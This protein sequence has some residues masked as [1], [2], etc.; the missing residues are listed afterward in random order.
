MRPKQPVTDSKMSDVLAQ[1]GKLADAESFQFPNTNVVISAANRIDESNSLRPTEESKPFI[2][3]KEYAASLLGGGRFSIWLSTAD[4]SRAVPKAA[5]GARRWGTVLIDGHPAWHAN[6]F[7]LWS[8]RGNE[9]EVTLTP[10]KGRRPSDA[11][12]LAIGECLRK[13]LAVHHPDLRALR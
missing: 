2:N 9:K 4:S 5:A 3:L 11:L 8:V 10:P 12:A 1:L 6:D 7:L 13:Y